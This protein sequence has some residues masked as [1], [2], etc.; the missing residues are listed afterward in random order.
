MAEDYVRAAGRKVE[1]VMTRDPIGVREDDDLETVVELMERRRVKRFPVLRD[2]KIVGIVSRANLM[3]ALVSLERTEEVPAGGDPAMR[4]LIV[5]AFAK[6]PWAPHVNVV[7]KE[8]VAELWGTIT[9]ERERQ[10]CVVTA[11]NVAGVRAVHDHLVWVEPISGMAFPS[12]EDEAKVRTV[13]LRRP[14]T[15]H[16]SRHS[17]ER[18]K[19]R[20][21]WPLIPQYTRPRCCASSQISC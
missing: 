17:A 5:A 4:E 10:A 3:L 14:C 12:P 9:D 20:I 19:R 18:D 11:E 8:S 16:P 6:Q 21:V 1:D 15:E 2:G 13:P 7:V